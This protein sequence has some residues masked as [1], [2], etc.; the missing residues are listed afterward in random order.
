MSYRRYVI[1]YTVFHIA[2]A[3]LVGGFFVLDYFD[4]FDKLLIYCPFHFFLHLYC[5]ACGGTRAA[6]LLLSGDIVGSL[7]YN[8]TTIAL[9]ASAVYY[10]VAA[11]RSLITRRLDYIK[12]V[13]FYPLYVTV[14][15]CLLYCVIRNV[16]LVNGVYDGIGELL[17]Y[18]K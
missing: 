3:V 4:V 9:L 1:F 8:P 12:G 15:V 7:L 11:L 5:P 13:R 18:W 6:W 10:E 14:G 17:P 16:L 2:A